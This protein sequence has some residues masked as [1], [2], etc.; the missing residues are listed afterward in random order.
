MC[1]GHRSCADRVTLH[2]P[3]AIPAQCKT[4]APLLRSCLP[5]T[6]PSRP[7][8]AAMHSITMLSPCYGPVSIDVHCRLYTCLHHCPRANHTNHLHESAVTDSPPV[9]DTVA[10]TTT[11]RIAH[12]GMQCLCCSPTAFPGL[13]ITHQ[14][15]HQPHNHKILQTSDTPVC[16]GP[17]APPGIAGGRQQQRRAPG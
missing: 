13:P 14:N 3:V 12:P 11:T 6:C 16:T 1:G 15:K 5:C 17:A 8:A 9:H 2:L 4:L 7:H 10:I